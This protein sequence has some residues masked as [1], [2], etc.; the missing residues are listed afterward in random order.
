MDSDRTLWLVYM[1]GYMT[2][3]GWKLSKEGID[4]FKDAFPE[5]P[6]EYIDIVL[7]EE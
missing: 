6:Q 3:K 7:E 5:I 1:I 2:S 4:D